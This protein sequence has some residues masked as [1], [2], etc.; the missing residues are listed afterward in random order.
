M[1]AKLTS[2]QIFYT[3]QKHGDNGLWCNKGGMMYLK[4]IA[5]VEIP[6]KNGKGGNSYPALALASPPPPCCCGWD[7]GVWDF[8]LLGWAKTWR[9]AWTGLSDVI[10]K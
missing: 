7:V 9:V 2:I 4:K 6:C 5:A 1:H 8:K 10:E 3:Y